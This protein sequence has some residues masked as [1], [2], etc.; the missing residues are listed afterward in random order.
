VTSRLLGAALILALSGCAPTLAPFVVADTAEVLQ[1]KQVAVAGGGGGTVLAG[2]LTAGLCCGGGEL[3]ARLGI[4]AGQEVSLTTALVGV[5]SVWAL[6]VKAGWKLSLAPWAALTA[7]A[8]V[9]VR[10]NAGEVIA[11][12]GAELGAIFST[13][14]VGRFQ[15]VQLYGGA[16]VALHVPALSDPFSGSGIL[17]DASVPI[18][19]AVHTSRTTRLFFEGGL[20]AVGT[21]VQAPKLESYPLGGFYGAVAFEARFQ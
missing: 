21:W 8:D 11:A 18:G 9:V 6:D 3:R 10:G 17:L 12:P 7:G 14:A 16:R 20:L 4:G 19:L 5:G 15:R 13:P 1:P 2:G